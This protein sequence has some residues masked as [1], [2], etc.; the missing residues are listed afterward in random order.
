MLL[1]EN[2]EYVRRKISEVVV[3][4]V[5]VEEWNQRERSSSSGPIVSHIY[6]TYVNILFKGIFRGNPWDGS[7]WEFSK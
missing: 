6:V 1:C 2:Y 5:G 3:E 4:E 7:L